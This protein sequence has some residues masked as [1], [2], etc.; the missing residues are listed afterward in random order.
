MYYNLCFCI[1]A[2][3]SPPTNVRVQSKDPETIV[4]EWEEPEIPDGIIIQVCLYCRPVRL[5]T[6]QWAEA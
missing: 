6:N 5:L 1:L 3:A 4:V 2:P